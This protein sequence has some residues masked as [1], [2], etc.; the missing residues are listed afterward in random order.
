MLPVMRLTRDVSPLQKFKCRTTVLVLM[1][2]TP[3]KYLRFFSASTAL[4]HTK[5]PAL[6]WPFAKK[7]PITITAS[8]GLGEHTEKEPPLR[9]I[10]RSRK[11]TFCLW[12]LVHQ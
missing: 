12:S 3:R 1:K 9:F 5:E 8:S 2:L 11:K 10:F 6:A 4:K 7:S